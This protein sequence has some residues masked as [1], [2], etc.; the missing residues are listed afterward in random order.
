MALFSPAGF[1]LP[2]AIKKFAHVAAPICILVEGEDLTCFRHEFCTRILTLN[3][4]EVTINMS[5]QEA[6]IS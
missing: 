2:Q 4:P 5:W 3:F 1:L 6:M